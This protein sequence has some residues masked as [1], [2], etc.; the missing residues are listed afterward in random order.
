[1][2]IDNKIIAAAIE[3]AK[4]TEK[5]KFNQTVDIVFTLREFDPKKAE[6]KINELVEL[7]NPLNK[8]INICVIGSSQLALEAKKAGADRVIQRDELE[9][10]GKDKKAAR[11]LA[12]EYEFFISEASLMPVV[13]KSIGVFLGPRGKMPTPVQPNVPIGSVI[14]RYRKIVKLRVKDQPMIQCKVGTEDMPTDKIVENIQTV[15]RRLEEKLE[16][17]VKSI[18]AIY[19]KTTMGK[20]VKV[21][22]GEKRQ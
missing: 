7:P 16:H 3:K 15:F 19:V 12:N 13:G 18:G 22:F 2:P 1:L 20:P 9:A 14:E 5:K 6:N 4:Q 10:L 21:E 8:K 17:G 11:K